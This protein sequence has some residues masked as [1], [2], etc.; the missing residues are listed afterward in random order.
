MFIS[1]I[2]S[3]F[4]VVVTTRDQTLSISMQ[5][6]RCEY[7]QQSCFLDVLCREIEIEK[8]DESQTLLLGL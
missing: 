7:K 1:A 4:I 3:C 2:L 6:A 5:G 8:S